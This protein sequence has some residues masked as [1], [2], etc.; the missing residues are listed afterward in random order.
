MTIRILIADDQQLM[1]H[2][3]RT[4]ISA[5]ADLEVVGEAGDTPEL[6]RFVYQLQPDLVLLDLAICRGEYSELLGDLRRRHPTVRTLILTTI[7]REDVI[8]QVLQAGANG[9]LLKSIVPT[10]L[11]KALRAAST[12]GTPLHPRIASHV[13]HWLNHPPLQPES[14]VRLTTRE[15]EI[16]QLVAQGCSNSEIARTLVI[17]QYTVRSHVCNI[18]KKLKLDNRTQA[19][20]YL[21]HRQQ[22][23][24]CPA[25]M[26]MRSVA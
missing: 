23:G 24:G 20:L 13:L 21:V 18:L 8:L 10:D 19:A 9:Y 3:L 6:L 16:L 12:G 4:L 25:Q 1:R 2:A 5:E 11:V 17:T 26:G 22:M 7:E 14:H 15:Q